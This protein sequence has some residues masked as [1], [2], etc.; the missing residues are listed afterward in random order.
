ME[1]EATLRGKRGSHLLQ[2]NTYRKQWKLQLIVIEQ[3]D[4]HED[5]SYAGQP[6]REIE[7]EFIETIVSWVQFRYFRFQLRYQI[8][9]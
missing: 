2:Q 9:T 5:D 3:E 8:V 4:E 6:A 7:H 1:V